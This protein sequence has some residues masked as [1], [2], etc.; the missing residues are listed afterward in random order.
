[1][2]DISSFSISHLQDFGYLIVANTQLDILGISECARVWADEDPEKILGSSL[3]IFF[4]KIF[5][6]SSYSFMQVI[7]ELT[8]NRIPRQIITKKIDNQLY[9]FKLSLCDELL[10][11]EWEKQQ[12]K[13]ILSSKMN[14]LG[15][16]F[17]HSY[18]TDWKFVCSALNRLL[19]FD[20]VFVLQVLETGHSK[21]IAEHAANGKLLFHKKE[22]SQRFMPPSVLSYYETQSYRYIPDLARSSQQFYTTDD[23]LNMLLSQLVCPPELHELYLKNI[24]VNAALFFPLFINDQ[25]WGLVIAHNDKPKKVDLQKR[26]LCSFIVQNAMS[27]Y[28]NLVKQGLLDFNQ[29]ILQ[30]E[31]VFKE[32]LATNK[33]VN[34]A[35]VNNMDL[36]MQMTKADGLAVY[37]QGD[38]F[39][40]GSCPK[41]NQFYEIIHYIQKTTDKTIFKDY[42]F[43]LNHG[44]FIS[45]D[46]P[47]AGLLS[48]MVGK[49]K[50]HYLVWFRKETVS[51]ITQMEVREGIIHIWEESIRDSAIPWDGSE[52]NFVQ[53]LHRIVNESIIYKTKEKSLLTEELLAM[54]NELEMFTFTLSHDLKNPLSILKM[55]LQFLEVSDSTLPAEKRMHWYKNLLGSI[56]NIEDI[57]NN[58]VTVSQNKTTAMAKDPVPMSY[59]IRKLSQEM[60]MLYHTEQC[61]FHFGKLFPLWG[62]K[63]ALYQVFLNLIGNAVKYSSS[64]QKPQIWIDSL[65]DEKEVCYSIKD[66][67]IGIPPN[68]LPHIFDMFSRAHNTQHFQGSGI[69][70]SLVKRIM[71]RLGG[72]IEIHS[73]EAEGT[74]IKLYFPLVSDFP[75]SML[76]EN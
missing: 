22:F 76:L 23:S 58:I 69:G 16:L 27:K 15:F 35:M 26:K 8:E 17:D 7:S 71:D 61:Q 47:F 43:K 32:K 60:T 64:K 4:H 33:T 65:Q 54:N 37:H 24:G 28:E 18:P 72:K 11:I 9:Y 3:E 38:L 48:Y 34:C 49:D 2:K 75:S 20:R 1:M 30:T 46:L 40:H 39:F 52:L 62:E 59:T 55:G 74:E 67:G 68:S 50:D 44:Q 66:N 21:V 42:N 63:S 12:K 5:N 51:T 14:E 36:L 57:I 25:F 53:C 70:L 31:I 29:Q 41:T 73:Q 10:Y 56:L 45:E 19:N 13:H 6:I